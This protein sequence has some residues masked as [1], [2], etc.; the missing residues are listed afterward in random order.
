VNRVTFLDLEF[1]NAAGVPIPGGK[2]S[3]DIAAETLFRI[4]HDNVLCSMATITAGNRAHINTGYFCYSQELDLYFLSHPDSM[5][6]RNL[7]SN[8]SMAV[9]IFSSAQDWR[10]PGR[11]LQLF[12]NSSPA[13]GVGEREAARLYGERFPAYTDWRANLKNADLALEYRFYHFV[14]ASLKL[15]DEEEFGDGVFLRAT[16]SRTHRGGVPL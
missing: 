4:L 3:H 9:T 13:S 2:V 15:L 10:R 11:G 7:A 1:C 12:G 16:I 8:S 5:H 6:C 14:A